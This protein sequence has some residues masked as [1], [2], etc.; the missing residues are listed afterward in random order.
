MMNRAFYYLLFLLLPALTCCTNEA[1]RTRMRSGLDSLNVRNRTDLPFTSA[2]VQ[3][4]A[5]YFD[6]HG[7]AND[8][9][10]AHYLMGRAYHEQG[11]APMALQCYQQAAECA[12][13]TAAD[14]DYA[15][16]SRVFA[17]M[18]GIFYEQQLYRYQLK[19]DSL[20]IK[21]A[22]MACDT[23]AALMT[24]EQTS[25]TYQQLIKP[26]SAISVMENVARLFQRYGYYDDAT[27]AL[28]GI[29]RTLIS[30]GNYEKAR[31]YMIRYELL[32][33]KDG[34]IEKGREAYYNTKGLLYY[35]LSQYDSA[36]YW[37]RKELRDGRDLNN[38]HGGAYG[39]AMVYDKQQKPDSASKYYRYAY[40]TY[41]T[42]CAA[43]STDVIGRLQ[44][45]YDY[46]RH[47]TI[48]NQK[49]ELA[50]KEKEKR[51]SVTILLLGVICLALFVYY[52][53]YSRDKTRQLL[54]TQ[55]LDK[56]EQVQSEVMNLRSLY[57]DYEN[58]ST[59][60]LP[61]DTARMPSD[62]LNT[63]LATKENEIE[64]LKTEMEGLRM[65][66]T[67]DH[68]SIDKHI[69]ESA[70]YQNLISRKKTTPLTIEE[71]KQ[72]R[73]LMIEYLP[74]FN[75]L[76]SGKQY[77]LI[78]RDYNV[79]MLFRLGFKSKEISVML[80]VSQARIS[81]ICTKVLSVVFNTEEGGAKVL[82]E[83]LFELY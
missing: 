56:L 13:T 4:Y 20:A 33:F 29:T 8:R 18:G 68:M 14:C 59:G 48:A 35:S 30:V 51:I 76:L 26:D 80:G 82:I 61:N 75:N 71:I 62:C 7:T 81:Q 3:P 31:E 65:K 72:C 78:S 9:L 47:Q 54:Y 60:G 24:M 28:G 46:S 34:Q 83:K 43:R 2:D 11:E 52:R 77:K 41:D 42:L 19:H 1:E 79:C 40:N 50:R 38:Q 17:Q 6:R 63:L 22:W 70:V 64:E 74:V 15:Q 12:D 21:Y 73:L 27:I 16:L 57:A 44:A 58:I 49:E 67:K 25:Y 23:L 69:Q 37:Y 10:L 5:D 36:A 45:L 39:L 32:M 53:M 66:K 55:T